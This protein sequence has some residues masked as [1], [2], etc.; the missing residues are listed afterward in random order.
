[1]SEWIKVEDKLP[2]DGENVIGFWPSRNGK[3]IDGKN[4]AVTKFADDN[5]W[6]SLEDKDVD[7]CFP[8]HWMPLPEPPK[9]E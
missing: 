3:K 2:K 8:S 9:Q 5:S 6:W 7:F 1:M 4:F